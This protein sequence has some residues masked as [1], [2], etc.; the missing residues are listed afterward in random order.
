MLLVFFDIR[1]VLHR[2]SVP[3]GYTVDAETTVTSLRL[4]KGEH[5][6]WTTSNVTP[7][8]SYLLDLDPCDLFLFPKMKFCLWV[9]SIHPCFRSMVQLQMLTYQRSQERL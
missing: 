3:Q 2:E 7:H 8:P 5:S 1:V 4:L 9:I 6:V